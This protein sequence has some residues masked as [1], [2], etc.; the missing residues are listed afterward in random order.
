MP[1]GTVAISS[2]CSSIPEVI[3]DSRILFNPKSTADLAD[4]LLDL[5]NILTECD[6]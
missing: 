3:G 1:Y 4:I 5:L 2:N 6:A